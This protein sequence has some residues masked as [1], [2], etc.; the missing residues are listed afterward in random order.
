MKNR[1]EDHPTARL[2]DDLVER[3]PE[4]AASVRRPYEKPRMVD[5]GLLAQVALGG[6][7]GWGDS[8]ST[9]TQRPP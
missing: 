1:I 5:H 9:Q 3:E 4:S 6:S 7:P 2:S 8:G